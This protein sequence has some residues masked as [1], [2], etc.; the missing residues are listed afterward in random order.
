VLVTHDDLYD[1]HKLSA[2]LNGL[3]QAGFHYKRGAYNASTQVPSTSPLTPHPLPSPSSPKP[4]PSSSPLNPSPSPS[5]SP[6]PDPGPNPS[7]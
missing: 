7:P 6:D 5:P 2:K 3:T 4:L 1:Q